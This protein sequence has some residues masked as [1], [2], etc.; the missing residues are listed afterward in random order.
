MLH[1]SVRERC[2]EDKVL[3]SFRVMNLETHCIGQRQQPRTCTG[4]I[5]T[6]ILIGNLRGGDSGIINFD[7]GQLKFPRTCNRPRGSRSLADG[8]D[9]IT[10]ACQIALPSRIQKLLAVVRLIGSGPRVHIVILV[11]YR[12]SFGASAD[13]QCRR[14]SVRLFRRTMRGADA[15]NGT[16]LRR[17]MIYL[18]ALVIAIE[19]VQHA[20]KR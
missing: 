7:L 17:V 16:V 3:I 14:S 19:T 4:K 2:I 9:F 13:H 10:R 20:C 5:K 6:R 15:V 12:N 18:F 11:Q 8:I 1:T